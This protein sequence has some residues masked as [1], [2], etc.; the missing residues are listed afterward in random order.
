MYARR[1]GAGLLIKPI[2]FNEDDHYDFDKP[3]NIS[4]RLSASTPHGVFLIIGAGREFCEGYQTCR[5]TGRFQ[6][7]SAPFSGW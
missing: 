4:P 5:L 6:E 2:L 3:A 7:R 1:G